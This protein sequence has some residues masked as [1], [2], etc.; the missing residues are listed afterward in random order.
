MM[1]TISEGNCI[2]KRQLLFKLVTIIKNSNN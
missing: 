2:L 1:E